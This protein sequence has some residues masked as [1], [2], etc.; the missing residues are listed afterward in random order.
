[1]VTELVIIFNKYI[2]AYLMVFCQ[3]LIEKMRKTAQKSYQVRRY[4]KQDSNRVLSEYKFIELFISDYT[5]RLNNNNTYIET[6]L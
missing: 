3:N 4:S 1:M 2:V 5:E 6:D